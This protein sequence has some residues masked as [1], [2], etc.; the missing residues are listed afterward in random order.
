MARLFLV[1]H[2]ETTWNSS[3]RAQGH[4][5]TPLSEAG[6]CQ[7]E[8]LKARL[9][10]VEFAAAYSSDLRRAVD[11]AEVILRDRAIPLQTMSEL[12]EKCYGVWEGKTFTE[13][14]SQYPDL[15]Q[16]LFDDDVTFMPPG[17]ESDEEM[18]TRV[19]PLAC[20]FTSA[21]T[22]DEDVL[23][24]GHGGSLRALLIGLLE[25]PLDFLWRFKLAN[26]G[27]FLVSVY[28]RGSATLDLLNDTN[29]LEAT[30]G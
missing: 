2:C 19:G 28:L 30:R 17:G 12:R 24:V 21:Y 20:R 27:I 23:I 15:Y 10:S 25:M 8:R 29:H 22:H 13:I 7:A 9:A 11:T 6:G 18:F 4:A 5:D 3:G 26:A 1:R 14:Q 16:Q